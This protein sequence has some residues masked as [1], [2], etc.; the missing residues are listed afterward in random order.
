MLVRIMAGD[1]RASVIRITFDC[2]VGSTA[3]PRPAPRD[4]ALATKGFDGMQVPEI[5]V[6][7]WVG[8][9]GR[10]KGPTVP[11]LAAS[12]QSNGLRGD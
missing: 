5:D 3:E 9:Y 11:P 10:I 7:G 8:S 4:N 2:E 12:K 6:A 1:C